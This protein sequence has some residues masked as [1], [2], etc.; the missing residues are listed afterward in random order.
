M[1]EVAV[2]QVKATE[3]DTSSVF[4]ELSKRFEEVRRRAFELFEKRG[5]EFGHEL[6]DWL[7]AERD[8]A[9]WPAAEMKEKEAAYELEITLPGFEAKDVQVTA[10]PAEIV[11]HA[12][13][14]HEKKTEEGKVL[15]TEFGSN[16]VY[17][18]FE[19]PQPIDP[20]KVTAKLEKGMLRIQAPK[21]APAKVKSISVA[22]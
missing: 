8:V 16:D 19:T 6:E 20:E 13:Y 4:A 22:A 12:A 18:R 14:V 21:A 10:T 1:P 3:R 9:G 5:F 11:V 2:Q 7:K 15:W 17:R